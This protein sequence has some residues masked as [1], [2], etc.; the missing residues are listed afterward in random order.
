MKKFMKKLIPILL[1][2]LILA[3]LVWY[4]FVYDRNATRDLLLSQARLFSTYGYPKVANFFYDTAYNFTD[5]DDGVAIELA[6]QFK[7]VGNYT[8]AEYTLSHA[9]ADGGTPDLYMALC[10]TYVEQDKLLDAVN[11]LDNIQDPSIKRQLDFM[12]PKAPYSDPEPGFFNQYIDVTLKSPNGTIYYTTNGE[13]PSTDEIPYADPITL[14][15]GETNIYAVCVGE[16]GLVSPLSI[17]SYTV[18]G[19]IEEVTF[20]DSVIEASVRELLA[21]DPEDPI[22]TNQLW[23]IKSYTVPEDAQSFG[24]LARFSYLESLTFAD[25]RIES[26][27]FLSSLS[28]LKELSLTNC[29]ISSDE[30]S[31]I[32][33]LPALRSLT[34]EDCGLSTLAGLEAAQNLEVLNLAENTVQK[35]DPISGIFTLR[36]IDLR[37]N[38]VTGLSALS[39]LVNLEKLDVSYNSISSIAP[40]ATCVKL[41][42]LDASHNSLSNLSG[43]DNLPALNHLA[44]SHNSLSDISILGNCTTLVELDLGNNT[45]Q[46]VSALGKLENLELLDFPYNQIENLPSW[47]DGSALRTINGNYNKIKSVSSLKNLMEL[48]HI[49]MD[50]NEIK[51]IAPLANCYKLVMVNVYGNTISGEDKLLDRDIIVNYNP[52]E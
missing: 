26:L 14:P 35:L 32:A 16:D 17:L 51:D 44:A 21:I 27:S 2:L 1:V 52:A 43:I 34:L 29:K 31:I 28:F 7:A 9:I 20:E 33:S 13:Y 11:M 8:K 47:P 18:G 5:Q 48:T 42:W 19:V 22:F 15:A 41:A 23:E 46:D 6:N 4:G 38:A 10:K 50:Y 24:D 37:N 39:S 40:I 49:Y 3:S 12:R 36:S 45:I 30:L 25:H